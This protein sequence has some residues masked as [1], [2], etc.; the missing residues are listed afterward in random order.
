M[1]IKVGTGFPV[2]PSRRAGGTPGVAL[3]TAAYEHLMQQLLEGELAPGDRLSVVDI[4]AEL[5]CSRVPVMEALKRLDAEGFVEIIPQV[6]CRVARPAPDEVRDFFELFASVEG[7]VTRLAALRRTE[8]DLVAFKTLCADIDHALRDAGGPEACDPTYRRL[9]L[10]FHT[11]LHRYARA[12]LACAVA[13]GMWDRSDFFIRLAFGSLYFNKRVRQAHARI[14]RAVI[15]GDGAA[16]EDA[17]AEHLRAV[18]EGVAEK[19]AAAQ[20]PR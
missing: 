8:A 9:N 11:A 5:A 12:P 17:V 10:E 7:C 13:A 4:A 16:A 19:L 2:R 6:G 20:A 1:T 15:D 18:G 14:R 3:A